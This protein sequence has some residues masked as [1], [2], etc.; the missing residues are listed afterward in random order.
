MHAFL[1]RSALLFSAASALAVAGHA[2]TFTY[3]TGT[4]ADAAAFNA[5]DN[6][7][8]GAPDGSGTFAQ[9]A[10]INNGAVNIGGAATA[11]VVFVGNAGGTASLNIGSGAS[12]TAFYLSFGVEEAS[13]GTGTISG[14]GVVTT[15]GG[16][17]VGDDAVFGPALT[18]GL[19]GSLTI[20]LGGTLNGGATVAYSAL[21][22]GVLTLTGSGSTVNGGISAF[23]GAATITIT[24]SAD[25]NGYISIGGA[26]TSSFTIDNAARLTGDIGLQATTGGSATG[27]IDGP[28]HGAGD[29]V[30]SNISVGD[31]GTNTLTIQNGASLDGSGASTESRVGHGLGH[32]GALIL[33]GSGTSW[34][35]AGDLSIGGSGTGVFTVAAGAGTSHAAIRLGTS[36]AGYGTLNVNNASSLSTSDVL[37]V[38]AEGTGVMNITGGSTVTT[39]SHGNI[40]I[41]S[42]GTG[43]VLIT[44]A[45]SSWALTNSSTNLNVG[46]GGSGSITVSAGATLSNAGLAVLGAGG[47]TGSGHVTVTGAGSSWT[48]DGTVSIGASNNSTGYITV[49]QGGA[50]TITGGNLLLANNTG[51]TGALNIGAASNHAAAAPGTVTLSSGAIRTLFGAGTVVFNHTSSNYTFAPSM[52]LAVSILHKSGTTLLTGANTHTGNTLLTGGNLS[53]G[54]NHA[55]GSGNLFL[56]G[57]SLILN[58]FDQAS[59]T[60]TLSADSFIDFGSLDSTLTFAD[61]SALGWAGTLTVANF[62]QGVDFFRV[63]TTA[64]GLTGTQLNLINLGGFYAQIDSSGYLTASSTAFAIPEPSTYGALA[65]LAALGLATLR[66]KS[67]PAVAAARRS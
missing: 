43:T 5:T 12:L 34:T 31:T 44:G 40:G 17:F 3:W 45:C 61:S 14:T 24:D 58:N 20:S 10:A 62:T 42:G 30:V 46:T 59:G 64:G 8:A 4:G 35:N 27:T 28:A 11:D 54:A 32:N 26:G 9:I 50:F 47:A 48:N 55:L 49:T 57:G 22:T 41:L 56:G 23:D 6:W 37:Q 65:G 7:T 63:G 2:Q 36:D 53:L 51:S 1:R 13:S 38:G 39:G 33:T 18:A 15:T 52:D 25:L 29:H 66:R 60:L 67:R 16:L 21:S 19:T